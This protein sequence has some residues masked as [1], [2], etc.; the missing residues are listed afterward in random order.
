MSIQDLGSIG[1]FLGAVAV[2]VT[3]IYLAIQTR[4]LRK[5]SERNTTIGVAEA[6]AR[7]RAAHYQ[8]PQL[9]ELVAKDN[10]GDELTE[11]EKLQ[12]RYLH[13]DLFIASIIGHYTA[14]DGSPRAE[15]DYLVG[16]LQDNPGVHREWQNQAHLVEQMAPD[17]VEIINKRLT[18]SDA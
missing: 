11:G 14:E 15:I 17:L 13:F 6:H 12:I 1:E 9:A 7:W 18:A 5:T 8:N 3:L 16:V 2:L 10:T 4:Q